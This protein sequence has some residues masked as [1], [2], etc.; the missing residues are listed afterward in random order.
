VVKA[1]PAE[2][3]TAAFR[4]TD[5]WVGADGA[6]SVPLSDRRALWLF[7]DTLVGSV[8]NGKRTGVTMVNNTVGI[9]EGR[10]ADLKLSFAIK[11][12]AAGKAAAIFVPPDGKGWFWL[13]A[14]YHTGGKLHVFLPKSEHT[15]SGGAF[16]FRKVAVW[17]GSVDNPTA[18]PTTWKITYAKMPFAEFD[19]D[20]S[21]AF[22]SAVVRS[23]DHVY[24]YG[25]DQGPG[26]PFPTR[27]LLVARAP[28]DAITDFAGWR[29]L[30][31]D[32]AWVADPKAAA[33][34]AD[35]LATECSVSY[36]PGLKRYALV[37]TEHGFGEKIIGRFATVPE[38]PWSAPV[39]LYQCPEMA[40]NK[41][42]FSYAAKAHPHLA[43]D[44]E[45]VVSYCVNAFDLG[46]VINDATLY[47]PN[48]VRI[49]LK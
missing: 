18:D 2:A 16:G 37:Y 7:S 15:G 5:G 25:Y 1:E 17:L 14:G 49:S 11:R 26:K 9:Q 48:F 35:R 21:R 30:A 32:G 12:D 43:G 33:P 3:L 23:G 4:Q 38:G 28:A 42:L 45:L 47:W 44:S 31:A 39:V 24:V 36:L 22:G 29:F 27:S 8:K 10:G 40:Q 20:R 41:R 19:G 13:Y 34:V 46:T 6:Y